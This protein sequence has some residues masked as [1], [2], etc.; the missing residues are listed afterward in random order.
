LAK[1]HCTREFLNKRC[2][3][4]F[5]MGEYFNWAIGF[6]AGVV[7]VC[8][9]KVMSDELDVEFTQFFFPHGGRA[10]VWISRPVAVAM[11]ARALQARGFKFE[12][13]NDG[14]RIWMTCIDHATERCVDRYCDD[15]H[16][17]PKMVDELIV[18]AFDKFVSSN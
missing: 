18:E 1:A 12:I 5:I 7:G 6:A 14:G 17:V 3:H 16:D 8:D 10:P 9:N 13:E 15:G 11:S 2:V 4:E